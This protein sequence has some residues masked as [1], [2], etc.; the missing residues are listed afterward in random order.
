MKELSPAPHTYKRLDGELTHLRLLMTTMGHEVHGQLQQALTAF[1]TANPALAQEVMNRDDQVDRLEVETD[2]EI[3]DLLARN[4]PLGSDLRAALT[5]LKSVG[6][7]E[8]IG[9]EATRIASLVLLENNVE[10]LGALN[11]EQIWEIEKVAGMVLSHYA[12][13]FALFENW[14]EHQAQQIIEGYRLMNGL[15]ELG[16]TRTVTHMKTGHLS[17]DQGILLALLSRSLERIA[18]HSVNLAE[19]GIYEVTGI[20]LR[21]KEYLN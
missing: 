16:L 17:V 14:D 8:K 21:H 13:A 18:H 15:F 2:R 7:L 20:D 10:Q 12:S 3:L 19:Y 6:E 5:V 11:T 4:S 1:K 9:D